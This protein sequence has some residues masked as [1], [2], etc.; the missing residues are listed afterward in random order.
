MQK[1]DFTDYLWVNAFIV[2]VPGC[3][4]KILT[5]ISENET[6]PRRCKFSKNNTAVLSQGIPRRMLLEEALRGN[7]SLEIYF[8][9]ALKLKS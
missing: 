5:G 4:S 1:K 8:F 9:I 3:G 7:I 6:P 2:Q